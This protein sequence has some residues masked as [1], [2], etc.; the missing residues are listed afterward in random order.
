MGQVMKVKDAFEKFGPERAKIALAYIMD[1]SYSYLMAK[2]EEVLDEY[3]LGQLEEVINLCD[4]GLPIQYAIGYWD[5][6]GR[7]FALSQ[8]VLIPRPETEILCEK[9]LSD[10]IKEKKVLDIGCG[11]GA[12]AISLKLEEKTARLYAS[13]ISVKALDIS[14]KNAKR[15]SAD[16]NFIHSDLFENI[17]GK[18]DVIVS[19]PP[20]ISQ[21][22][23]DNLDEIL[24]E[25]PKLAL[26]AGEKGYEIYEK[27]VRS[28]RDYLNDGG[29]VYFE[30][31][32]DQGPI[33]KQ[34]L[35]E[36][37]FSK[38]EIIKDYAGHDRVVAACL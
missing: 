36:E 20:Y 35:E 24:Y 5:F 18:F 27:I 34:L 9:I 31:G 17:L 8:D 13:D 1:V 25:E 7:T 32:Y 16:V 30:I 12:I 38:V 37:G 28:C 4:Q 23:Y 21:K 3:T 15:L 10:G 29:R 14:R 33:V 2:K 19:N 11:S 26:L 6:Y 22:D